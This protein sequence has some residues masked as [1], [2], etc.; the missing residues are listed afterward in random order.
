[1]KNLEKKVV[2]GYAGTMEVKVTGTAGNYEA[3]CL[4]TYVPKGQKKVKLNW[5][6]VTPGFKITGLTGLDEGVFKG[7]GKKGT[8]FKCT[9]ENLVAKDYEY[10]IEIAEISTEKKVL[11]DPTITNGGLE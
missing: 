4:D 8:G 7:K 6:M 3:T 9:D 1:M 10:S 11:L 2:T 5:E